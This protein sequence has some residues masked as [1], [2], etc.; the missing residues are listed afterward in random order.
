MWFACFATA[1][2]CGPAIRAGKDH[3]GRDD[4]K[5]AIEKLNLKVGDMAIVDSSPTSITL[6]MKSNFTNPT[7]YTATIPYFNINV[8]VNGTLVGSA[9][10]E[11]STVHPGN[12]SNTVVTVLWDPYTYGGIKGKDVGRE[13][14]S[15][16]ISGTQPLPHLPSTSNSRTGFNTSLT[17]QAHNGTI[18]SQPALG[19]LLS[20]FPITVPAPHMSTPDDDSP[21]NDEKNTHFI[22]SATMHILSSTALFTLFSP[23]KSTTMY[24]TSLNATAY[25]EGNDAGKI[26]Y[27]LPFAVPPGLSQSPRLPVDWSFGSLGYQAIRKALGGQLKLN[28]FAYVGVRIGEWRETIWYKGGKI[29]AN[30]RL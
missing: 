6:Q 18:P 14:L 15:Q 10:V 25:Y 13:W 16:F 23:F 29:S 3:D 19:H 20:R 30:V 12:N 1:N 7:N 24:L 4:G 28:A 21:P 26:L 5:S 2:V 8:L 11:N 22:R 17:M 9:T 27:D